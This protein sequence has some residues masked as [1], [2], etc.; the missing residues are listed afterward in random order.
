[1]VAEIICLYVVPC[2]IC[3]NGVGVTMW[4]TREITIGD[5][6]SA[7]VMVFVPM[8]NLMAAL[9]FIKIAVDEVVFPMLAPLMDIRI[10]RKKE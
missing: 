4:G 6:L 5:M 3:A 1:M 7:F 2:I 9:L 8:M 10:W